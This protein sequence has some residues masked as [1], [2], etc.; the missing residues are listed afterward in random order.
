MALAWLTPDSAEALPL[1][2]FDGEPLRLRAEVLEIDVARGQALFTGKVVARV[3]KLEVRA[4]TLELGY[5]SAARVTRVEAGG[6][7]TARYDGAVLKSDG[8]SLDARKQRAELHGGVEV[9][10]GKSLLRAKRATIDL[11]TRRVRLEQVSGS[12]S[13]QAL[14]GV[15]GAPSAA[16]SSAASPGAPASPSSPRAPSAPPSASAAPSAAAPARARGKQGG[17]VI[18]PWGPRR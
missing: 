3:G 12:V 5:D 15:D 16:S 2:T 13:L 17:E 11:D 6:G 1:T 7:V 9:R 8:L 14:Q 4:E 18:D 10:Q